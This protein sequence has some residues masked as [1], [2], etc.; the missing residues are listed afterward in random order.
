MY[1]VVVHSRSIYLSSRL[2]AREF[3]VYKKPTL[4][5]NSFGRDSLGFRVS[6]R[7]RHQTSRRCRVNMARIR[8]SRLDYGIDFQVKVLKRLQVVFSS[9][10]SGQG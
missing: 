10:G 7:C 5:E 3:S 6:S 8:Q 1:L 9:L 2:S 4:K